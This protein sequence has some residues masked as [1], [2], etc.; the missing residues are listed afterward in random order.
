MSNLIAG[1]SNRWRWCF[2][3]IN[4]RAGV[5]FWKCNHHNSA[6]KRGML[7]NIVIWSWSKQPEQYWQFIFWSFSSQF[8]KIPQCSNAM[9]Q[10]RRQKE[11]D[12]FQTVK[13]LCVFLTFKKVKCYFYRCQLGET[14]LGIHINRKINFELFIYEWFNVAFISYRLLL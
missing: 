7:Y 8:I 1:H 2:L 11:N 3:N 13:F 4:A 9:F 6:V 5:A 12:I 10:I 14:K